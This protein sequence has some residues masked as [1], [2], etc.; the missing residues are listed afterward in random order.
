[1]GNL[2][3]SRWKRLAGRGLLVLG[4]LFLLLQVVPY[5]RN[6]ANPPVHA[7]PKWDS[8]RT[9]ELAARA[10]FDC[11]SNE[12]RWPWYSHVA[13]MSW[14][15][16]RDVDQGRK[17]LNFSLWDRRQKHAEDAAEEVE[18]GD[19]PPR[20]YL[21]GHPEARFTDAEKADLIRGLRATLGD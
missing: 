4:G 20:P 18:E 10:C 2:P 17:E 5:G 9:R 19:M 12:T 7:E 14:L 6:H 8:P 21:W 1:M 16:Q 11:H 3:A 15:V 13:P